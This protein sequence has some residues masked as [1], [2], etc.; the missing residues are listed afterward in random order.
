[1]SSALT[2][3]DYYL[4]IVVS[5]IRL[6][7]FVVLLSATV[8]VVV[9]YS[10][11]KKYEARTTVFLEQNVITDLVKGIAVSPSVESKIKMLSVSLLSRGM[12]LKVI[13]DL[14]KDLKL[15]DDRQIE[16][17]L[18]DLTSRIG[19]SF[20]ERQGVFKISLRDNDP[21]FARDFV[22]TLTRKYIDDNTSS[23]RAESFEAT[24]FLAEQIESFRRRID[25]AD[26]AI[27]KY[28]SEKGMLLATDEVY[29]RGEILSAERKLEDLALK[30]NELE[31]RKR[32]Y[33]DKGPEP[34]RLSEAEARLSELLARYTP[35]NPKVVAAQAEVARLRSGR[36][37]QTRTRSM[38]A[39][40]DG[41]QM[42]QIE[43]DALK[44]LEA[45]QLRIIE[46]SNK[47]LREIP[48]VKAGLSELVRKKENE[49]V[50]YQQLVARYGQSEV[51]KQMELQD[52]SITFRVLD[53]AVAPMAPIS[54]NRQLIIGGS[55]AGGIALG[56]ALILL[57][58][59]FK[60]GI[61]SPS[62][63]KE[64]DIPVFAVV[65]HMPDIAADTNRQRVNKVL[66]L[67]ATGYLVLIMAIAMGDSF[68]LGDK[69][70]RAGAMVSDKITS[71]INK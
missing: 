8:G 18:A 33:L 51:S 45:R 20:Q 2:Q 10:L 57:L 32:L 28:K 12:L 11:P 21:I 43:I 15:Q 39:T 34:G 49:G 13:G 24:R 1:M 27:N 54:P 26:D 38:A 67:F 25:A 55:A 47:L 17:Y 61:K 59:I 44:E 68:Q 65:P 5:R 16:A 31:A 64:L 56:L 22:N 3:Y 42:V 41:V 40:K 46:E 69:M 36:G 7:I 37:D 48:N 4:R 6:F 60:G 66:M 14:D 30:R 70:S 63:L 35:E 23:K 62:E 19:I 52:K 71:L 53:P 29:L 50:V 58:D 9:A